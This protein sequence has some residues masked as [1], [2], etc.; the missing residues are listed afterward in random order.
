MCLCLT[1]GLHGSLER[2]QHSI[3]LYTNSRHYYHCRSTIS[4]LAE[5]RSATHIII[6]H[7][8]SSHYYCCTRNSTSVRATILQILQYLLLLHKKVYGTP[9]QCLC[10]KPVA[11]CIRSSRGLLVGME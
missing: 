3:T 11:A 2:G 9:A 5:A 10:W 8:N 1:S 7:T 6:V 4:V